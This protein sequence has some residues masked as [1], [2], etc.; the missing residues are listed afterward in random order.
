MGVP[1]IAHFFND[2][3]PKRC[4]GTRLLLT[5]KQRIVFFFLMFFSFL[6][7]LFFWK[8]KKNKKKRRN[9]KE[10]KH[11]LVVVGVLEIGF[12]KVTHCCCLIH[13]G[14]RDSSFV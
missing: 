2:V 1:E 11:T 10:E 9:E 14:A 3:A 7:L 5:T 8:R 4:F 6:F 12:V 13:G